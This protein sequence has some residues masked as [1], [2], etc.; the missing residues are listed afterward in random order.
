MNDFIVTGI[1][2]DGEKF[3]AAAFYEERQLTELAVMPFR[4]ESQVGKIYIGYMFL[5]S[6]FCKMVH[7]LP[8]NS[9]GVFFSWNF[10]M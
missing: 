4:E 10:F 9:K 8:I 7:F 6:L 2:R 3:L 5:Y 1:E